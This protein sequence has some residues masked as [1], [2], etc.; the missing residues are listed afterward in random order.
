VLFEMTDADVEPVLAL[1]ERY[2][3]LLAPLDAERLAMLASVGR[4][5]VVRVEDAFA[6]FVITFRSGA[7]Y[8][9]GNYAWFSERYDEFAYLDR[10]VLHEDFRRRGLGSL[11]YD[12]IEARATP[13]PLTLEVNILP[14][15]EP[16]LAF[17]RGRG[18][19]AVGERVIDDHTVTMMVKQLG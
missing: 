1:N 17:H 13:G 5:D 14:P 8:D 16:S 11:V 4:V 10:I 12:E 19:E 18:F 3:H 2:V 7:D 6:G 9:S 15:N